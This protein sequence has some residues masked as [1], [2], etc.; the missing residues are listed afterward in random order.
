MGSFDH[1]GRG[2]LKS[3]DVAME[4][5]RK[6]LFHHEGAKST[7]FGNI[8]ARNLRV[9]RGLVVKASVSSSTAAW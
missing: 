4:R 9:L 3:I 5:T 8:K 1:C 7:K 6:M 2:K